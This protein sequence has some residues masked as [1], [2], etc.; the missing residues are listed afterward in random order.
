[1]LARGVPV[2]RTLEAVAAMAS[3][4]QHNTRAAILVSDDARFLLTAESELTSGDRRL[5]N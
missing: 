3:H 5:L 1:M 2:R 4:L